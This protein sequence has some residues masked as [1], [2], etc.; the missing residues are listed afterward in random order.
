[1][2]HPP[3]PTEATHLGTW[4]SGVSVSRTECSTVTEN[5]RLVSKCTQWVT[6]TRSYPIAIVQQ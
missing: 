3:K 1:M 6:N 4:H 2:E 5:V